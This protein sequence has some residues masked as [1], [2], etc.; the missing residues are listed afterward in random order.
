VLDGLRNKLIARGAGAV[1]GLRRL[2]IFKLLAVGEIVLLARDHM[3]KL[4]SNERHRL[5]DLVRSG[6]GRPS[7]LSA[8]ERDEL[9]ELIAKAEPRRFVGESANKLSPI[10]LPRR[11]VQGKRR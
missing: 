5:V 10:P 11:V 4:D 7:N 1:P 8:T 9:A 6:R 2:P 3:R